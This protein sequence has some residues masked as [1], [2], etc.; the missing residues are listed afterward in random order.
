MGAIFE[1]GARVSGSR[2]SLAWVAGV[3]AVLVALASSVH[4]CMPDEQHDSAIETRSAKAPEYCGWVVKAKA[5]EYCGWV[6]KDGENANC[7]GQGETPSW[8]ACR[9]RCD[10]CLHCKGFRTE[11]TKCW[12]KKNVDYEVYTYEA[13]RKQGKWMTYINERDGRCGIHVQFEIVEAISTWDAVQ[14]TSGYSLASIHSEEESLVLKHM[15]NG[16]HRYWIGLNDVAAEM[17]SNTTGWVWSDGSQVDYTNWR[18]DHPTI[19]GSRFSDCVLFRQGWGWEAS[20]CDEKY[21]AICRRNR[22]AAPLR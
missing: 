18:R 9:D 16:S 10:A 1:H 17:G 7:W 6:V 5:P 4:G 13:Q 19:V 14:C 11:G 22:L 20:K 21:K 3:S 15:L 8:E 2:L 12:M